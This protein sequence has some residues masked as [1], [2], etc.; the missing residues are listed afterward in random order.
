MLAVVTNNL[1]SQWLDI[2]W[3]GL[4][5]VSELRPSSCIQVQ[6]VVRGLGCSCPM[7]VP[8]GIFVCGH[9]TLEVSMETLEDLIGCFQ[10]PGLD[11]AYVTSTHIS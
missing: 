7:P 3:R 5:G 4:D 1:I 8:F 6:A 2:V 11:V 10:R 9:A